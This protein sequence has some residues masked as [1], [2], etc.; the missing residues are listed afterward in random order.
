MSEA[1][2]EAI[3]QAREARLAGET[4]LAQRLVGRAQRLAF[5]NPSVILALALE[6]RS[7]GNEDAADLFTSVLREH[8]TREAWLGLASAWLL[9]SET[10]Q[11]VEALRQALRHHA[12][13]TNLTPAADMIA[14]A[15]DAV[16]WCA[17]TG[18][19]NLLVRLTHSPPSGVT[20]RAT[21][22]ER[23]LALRARSDKL[24]F[25]A[26]LPDEWR[27]AGV[28]MVRFADEQLLGS[29]I[30]VASIVR[31]EGFVDSTNGDLHGWAWCPNHP[32]QDP[33]LSIGRLGGRDT[34][35]VV[36]ANRAIDVPHDRPLARPRGF[37]VSAA[38]MQRF[39]G[40]VQVYGHDGRELIGSPVDPS[41]ERRS[42]QAASR[43]TARLFPAPG[44]TS[45]SMPGL[46]RLAVPA[47]VVGSRR[48]G[49]TKRAVDVIVPVYGKLDLTLSCLNS[50]LADLPRWARL[51]VVDDASPDFARITRARK[52][53]CTT[54]HHA[55]DSA[56]Q[57]RLPEHRQCRHVP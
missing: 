17:L 6:K 21:L 10:N 34:L 41:A 4:D 23:S 7:L 50:V 15:V 57:S 47:H 25:A 29:P 18:A 56:T 12:F 43:Y 2:F 42:A 38:Q 14:H 24:S 44:C 40:L 30:S 37:Q 9:K 16:G 49:G 39:H 33:I 54:A 20:P 8:D 32:E 53:S 19:G 27:R 55:A 35:T 36:A 48:R 45:R 11:A 46:S 52:V 1:A 3:R 28:V 22:D 31:V 51:V 5:G 13:P 26:R